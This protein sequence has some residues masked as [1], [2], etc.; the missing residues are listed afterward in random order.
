MYLSFIKK[1]LT[2]QP[3]HTEKFSWYDSGD[4]DQLSQQKAGRTKQARCLLR[5]I[6]LLQ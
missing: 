3:T 4:D 5:D 2:N 1:L 6:S